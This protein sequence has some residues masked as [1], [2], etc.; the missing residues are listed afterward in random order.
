MMLSAHDLFA[1]LPELLVIF[2]ACAVLA[3]DP[4]TPSSRKDGLAWLSL[5]TMA[6]CM[7]LTAA[8][9]GSPTTAFGGL[10]GGFI[11]HVGALKLR[12]FAKRSRRNLASLLRDIGD[13]H[14]RAF[15]HVAANDS[16]TEAGGAAGDDGGLALQL[17]H[18]AAP[19]PWK[20]TSVFVV[21]TSSSASR[22]F[23]RPW[24]LRLVPPKGSSTPPPAP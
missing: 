9:F 3:L 1:I 15:G 19:Q 22:P 6:V 7:G 4:I 14:A 2:A 18:D 24:P 17:P 8:R 13:N 11:G 21:L 10:D 5:G 16:L 20:C 12:H 23:S